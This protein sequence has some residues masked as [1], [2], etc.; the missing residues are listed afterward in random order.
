MFVNYIKV[1]LRHLW[2][3]KTYTLINILGLSIGMTCAILLYLYV[4]DERSYDS[5]H[6]DKSQIYRVESDMKF[7]DKTYKLNI[8]PAILA[9]TLEQEYADVVQSAIIRDIDQAVV[10][11]GKQRFYQ[12][13]THYAD[14]SIFKMLTFKAI[15]GNTD[16]VLIK[17]NTAVVDRDLASKLFRSPQQAL[18]QVFYL[19]DS[20]PYTIEAVIENVP[21][22]SHF[23]PQMLA[24]MSTCRKAEQE[25]FNS[26]VNFGFTCFVKL[27]KGASPQKTEAFLKTIYH[28]HIEK[29]LSE[30]NALKM[31]LQPLEDIHLYSKLE[32]DYADTGDAQVVYIFAVIAVLIL[33]IASANY[34]NLATAKSLERAKEVGVR[35]VVGAYRGQ[36]IYQFLV[37]AL[38]LGLVAFILSLSLVELVLPQF[39]HL[40][41]KTLAIKYIEEPQ[42]LFF[43]LGVAMLTGLFSG[44][45]P[46]L[47][48]SQFQPS[49]VLKGKFT[50]S[51]RG[52]VLRKGLVVFQFSISIIMIT[53]TGVV[54]NQMQFI[55]KR[56][57][58]YDKDLMYNFAFVDS[59]NSKKFSVLRQQ[60][61]RNPDIKAVTGSMFGMDDGYSLSNMLIEQRD[62][63][64]KNTSVAYFFVADGYFTD[65]G[66]KIKQGRAFDAS[67]RGD[68]ANAIIVNEAFVRK[69][70]WKNPIGKQIGYELNA[71]GQ[72]VKKG[73]IVG[74][75][76]DFHMES[77]YRPIE[78]LMMRFAPGNKGNIRS[79][80]VKLRP[81]SIKKSLAYIQQAWDKLQP[82]TPFKGQFLDQRAASAY[83]SDRQRGQVFLSFAMIAIFIA[84]LGLFGLASFTARQRT[85]EIGIR[86]VLGASVGHILKLL[87]VGFVRLVLISSVIAFPL[88][89]YFMNQ[90]LQNFAYRTSMPWGVFIAAGVATLLIA[91]FTVSAQSWRTARVNPVQVLKDE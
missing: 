16:R 11:V 72:A 36:L 3:N 27:K 62:G 51:K 7:G 75:V 70:G 21:G 71:K 82:Q 54:Y 58:G 33:L 15:A 35:K 46:A 45:Y 28:Q 59:E 39:N 68:Y 30:G 86:K 56:S 37:E 84:C 14:P 74:V 42:V 32:G 22:N 60:L 63:T 44:G 6:R 18:G 90:W 5:Y 26:W 73:Q 25:E 67:N 31:H 43:L 2:R 89:Y 19:N 79:V 64:S 23:K 48:M 17:P 57:L 61:L 76:A 10:R 29:K 65:L 50:H 41:S 12:G 49:K 85:K 55:N 9:P 77:L 34:M 91:L 38:I 53:G 88:A 78:P 69:Q 81:G 24:S 87:S 66:M 4:Q 40:T 83:E 52:R 8:L 47:V 1:T 20:I 80:F 13:R